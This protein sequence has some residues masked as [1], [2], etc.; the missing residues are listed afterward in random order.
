MP[1]RLRGSSTARL[2]PAAANSAYWVII[3]VILSLLV[4]RTVVNV[5]FI[6]DDFLNLFYI[7]NWEPLSYILRPHGGHV[8]IARNAVFWLSY[9]LFGAWPE[10]YHATVLLTHLLN[11]ALLYLLVWRLTANGIVS[12]IAAGLWG[13]CPVQAGTIGWYSVYG[14]VLMTT[15]VLALLNQAVRA[16]VDGTALPWRAVITWPLLLVI[17]STCFGVGIGIT[18]VAPLVLFLLSP[19]GRRR[20]VICGA[21]LVLALGAPFLYDGALWLHRWY[22]DLAPQAGGI[23]VGV[24]FQQRSLT[25]QHLWMIV[26]LLACGLGTLVTGFFGTIHVFPPGAWIITGLFAVLGAI[27]F[28]RGHAHT[29]REL[30]AFTA[31]A[32]GCYALIAVGRANFFHGDFAPGAAQARYHYA[33]TVPFAA[34][35]GIVVTQIIGWL[36]LRARAQIGLLVLWLLVTG[37]SYRKSE[38]FLD[39]FPYA[40]EETLMVIRSVAERVNQA[41]LARDVTITNH[42]FRSIG[43]LYFG[44]RPAFPGWAAIYT[45]FF[46]TNRV[47]GKLVRFL[48]QDPEVVAVA[49]QGRR[50]ADLIIS[51]E[52]LRPCEYP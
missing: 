15:I 45:I 11:V 13:I 34:M 18:L 9:Q 33:G 39:L 16:T 44:N 30:L 10:Y 52:D 51:P 43:V 25:P 31:L 48:D 12:A 36:Q 6:R 7:V 3:P 42:P 14:Q 24:A 50:T 4:Y 20:V 1:A 22:S 35:L 17:A 47:H 5:Y 23:A 19:P 46:P 49:K 8:Q 2:P 27:V 21:L 37:W 26:Y 41:G 32:V 38:P 40:R 29:R 28:I